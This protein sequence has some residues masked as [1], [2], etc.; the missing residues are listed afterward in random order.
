[1]RTYES[2]LKGN[3]IVNPLQHIPEEYPSDEKDGEHQ[4]LSLHLSHHLYRAGSQHHPCLQHKRQPHKT[5]R[6]QT[7]LIWNTW[8]LFI[9]FLLDDL[10]GLLSFNSSWL[11]IHAVQKF[12]VMFYWSLRSHICSPTLACP[13]HVLGSSHWTTS[14][15]TTICCSTLVHVGSPSG[16]TSWLQP[17]PWWWHCSSCSAVMKSLVR[18]WKAWPCPTPYR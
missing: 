1:M 15:P 2:I 18:L 16:W 17:W 14:T 4:S 6:H 10:S 11:Y 13:C 12:Q 3:L 8:Y 7:S 9:F 5:V